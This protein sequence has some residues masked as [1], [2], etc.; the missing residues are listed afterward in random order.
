[1]NIT[2]LKKIRKR[3]DYV[4]T[5]AGSVYLR[6]KKDETVYSFNSMHGFMDWWIINHVSK[7]RSSKHWF[8]RIKNSYRLQWKNVKM[9]HG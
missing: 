3:Y 1:M 8:K 2:E 5:K 6:R 7:K 4:I 9:R